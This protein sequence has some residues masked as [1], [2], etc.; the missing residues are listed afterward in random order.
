MVTA[1]WA[2]LRNVRRWIALFALGAALLSGGTAAAAF[3]PIDRSLGEVEVPRVRAGTIVVPAAHKRGRTTVIL[4]LAQPPLAAYSRTLSSAGA[5]RRLN[6]SSAA[7]RAYVASLLRA[8]A[9]AEATLKRRS[10]RRRCTAT[11]RCS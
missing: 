8:Q 9:R 2:T 7:S 10:R 3:Q 5:T 11:T 6:T 4:T 1:R